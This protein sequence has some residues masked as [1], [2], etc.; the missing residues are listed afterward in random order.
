MRLL[1]FIKLCQATETSSISSGENVLLHLWKNA[2]YNA[3]H[4]TK[5]QHQVDPG[6]HKL[7]Q[8]MRRWY[9][10]FIFNTWSEAQVG[11]QDLS[12]QHQCVLSAWSALGEKIVWRSNSCVSL[13]MLCKERLAS[14]EKWFM[15]QLPF[16]HLKNQLIKLSDNSKILHTSHAV[17]YA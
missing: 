15:P 13:I 9:F 3:G 5:H 17:R 10:Q 12:V 16:Y 14:R 1:V 8:Y 2:F 6:F 7:P 4:V 11:W